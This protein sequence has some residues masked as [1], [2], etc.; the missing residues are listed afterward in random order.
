MNACNEGFKSAKDAVSTVDAGYHAT[1]NPLEE[2]DISVKNMIWTTA[3]VGV[4]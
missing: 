1:S 4:V 2:T 3:A